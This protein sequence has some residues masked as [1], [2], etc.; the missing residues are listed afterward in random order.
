MR[1]SA[2]MGHS[3]WKQAK[4]EIDDV[5]NTLFTILLVIIGYY[6]GERERRNR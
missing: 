2:F 4:P 3:Q 5:R 1:F 6:F